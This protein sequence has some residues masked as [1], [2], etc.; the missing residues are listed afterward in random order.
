MGSAMAFGT[1][2]QYLVP[3]VVSTRAFPVHFQHYWLVE[4]SVEPANLA[5]VTT[6]FYE[7]QTNRASPVSK[8]FLFLRATAFS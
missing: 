8:V 7:P 6:F 2:K 3:G 1:E 5:N 4:P